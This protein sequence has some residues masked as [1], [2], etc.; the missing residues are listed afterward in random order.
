MQLLCALSLTLA[1][2]P[3]T[4]LE[5]QERE[6]FQK[7]ESKS[8]AKRSPTGEGTCDDW[9]FAY[10]DAIDACG[11]F[12][13]RE[14]CELDLG[15]LICRK[16]APL[17]SCEQAIRTAVK[18]DSCEELPLDCAPATIADR[19]LP[20]E[21]CEDIHREMCEFR[22]FCGLE[23]STEA[24]LETL[25]HT[26]PCEEFTSFLPT[27]VECAEAYSTLGCEQGMPKVCAGALRY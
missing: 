16:D 5:D 17:G 25:A 18:S 14:Q 26:E 12:T 2:A 19:S 6:S 1:C 22:F 3:S 24:C 8:T 7:E 4:L 9:K 11:A 23:F 20:T 15:W 13:S 10:C 27:A 21:L